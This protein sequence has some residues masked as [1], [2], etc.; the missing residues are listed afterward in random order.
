MSD[1]RDFHRVQVEISQCESEGRSRLHKLQRRPDAR[2]HPA[3]PC[4]SCFPPA[5]PP[6]DSPSAAALSWPCLQCVNKNNLINFDDNDDVNEE[7]EKE[8]GDVAGSCYDY[9]HDENE[10]DYDHYH[11]QHNEDYNNE[12]EKDIQSPSSYILSL[13]FSHPPLLPL[14]PYSSSASFIPAFRT[15]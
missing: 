15:R 3:R 1:Q 6:P 14:L 11:H 10:N 7:V 12:D 13:P 4:A 9:N 8:D 2:L 5:P